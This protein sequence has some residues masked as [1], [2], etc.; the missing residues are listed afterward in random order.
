M[1]TPRRQ[2]GQGTKPA[3]ALAP[4]GERGGCGAAIALALVGTAGGTLL[5]TT[6]TRR[7]TA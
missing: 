3:E 4:G 5:V 6:R 2:L 7:S 1:V